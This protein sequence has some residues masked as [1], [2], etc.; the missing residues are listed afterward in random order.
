MGNREQHFIPIWNAR[1]E[2]FLLATKNS[3]FGVLFMILRR[4][5]LTQRKGLARKHT[6]Y[7]GSHICQNLLPLKLLIIVYKTGSRNSGNRNWN[8][9]HDSNLARL[10]LE[11][12]LWENMVLFVNYQV[13]PFHRAWHLLLKFT[14]KTHLENNLSLTLWHCSGI[15]LSILWQ[16]SNAKTN[17]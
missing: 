4:Q 2:F 6:T 16:D 14:S 13:F 10:S 1:P 15:I 7:L 11:L 3:M 17:K 9:N 8:Y 12:I 5:M